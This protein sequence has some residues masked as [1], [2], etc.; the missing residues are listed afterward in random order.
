[1]IF[2]KFNAKGVL[3]W[4]RTSILL[5]ESDSFCKKRTK[6]TFQTRKIMKNKSWTHVVDKR[7][8]RN[9]PNVFIFEAPPWPECGFC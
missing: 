7:F 1:M 6:M 9:A 4:P 5:R 3:G 2:F 8:Q